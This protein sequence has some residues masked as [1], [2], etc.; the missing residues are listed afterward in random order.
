MRKQRIIAVSTAFYAAILPVFSQDSE[1]SI[2]SATTSNTEKQSMQLTGGVE[3]KEVI[4]IPGAPA[5]ETRKALPTLTL[6]V[7][8]LDT[9]PPVPKF[10]T[11]GTTFDQTLYPTEG[12]VWYRIPKFLAGHWQCT[13]KTIESSIN[14]TTGRENDRPRLEPFSSQINQGFQADA[15][16][17]IWHFDLAPFLGHSLQADGQTHYSF[18]QKIEP[19]QYAEDRFVRRLIL[20]KAEVNGS[21]VVKTSKQFEV[22]QALTPFGI[23]Q[24]REDSVSRNIGESAPGWR[25]TSTVIYSLVRPYVPINENK[26]RDMREM[27]R[28]YLENNGLS[29]LVPKFGAN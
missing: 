4:T 27:F 3:Q 17:Q 22:I 10:L 12:N 18:V 23:N 29:Q 9:P 15:T 7:P 16:G 28:E 2:N 6:E 26:G 19:L 11:A 25:V 8:K 20:I 14:L 5:S 24:L 1:V 13:E 21:N